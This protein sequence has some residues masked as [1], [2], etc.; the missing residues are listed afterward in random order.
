MGER[1]SLHRLGDDHLLHHLLV[2][3]ILKMERMRITFGLGAQ[4]A[5]APLHSSKRSEGR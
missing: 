4:G 1:L 3:L 5:D 2:V